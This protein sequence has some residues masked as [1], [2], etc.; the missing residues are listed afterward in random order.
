M[1]ND[2]RV[3]TSLKLTPSGVVDHEQGRDTAPTT[4]FHR[5]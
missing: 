5:A 4:G 2:E 1:R 3:L